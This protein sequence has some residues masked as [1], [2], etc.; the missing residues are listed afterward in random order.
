MKAIQFSKAGAAK[1]VL[2]MV[3]IAPVPPA[4]GEV[5]VKIAYSAVNPTDVKR[6]ESGRELPNFSPII[7]GNDGAGIIT[8][9]GDG[10]EASRVGERVW[11]FGA[12]A[13]RA[14]GTEAEYCTLPTWMAPRLPD[15]A[16]LADGACLGVPAVTA[17]YGVFSD[18]PVEGLWVMV[19]G[20]AGRVGR[21]AVQM[22]KLAG[23]NV[24]ASVGN[25]AKAK[26]A[27]DAGA[28]HVIN[29]KTEDVRARVLEIT[30]GAG[31]NR[32][33]EVAFGANI[34]L[35][36]DIMAPNGVIT[37]YSSDAVPEP[38]L[39]YWPIMFKNITIRPY[40]IYAL[41]E[42]VKKTTFDGVNALL[43]AGQLTHMVSKTCPFTL[44]GVIDAHE[45][46]ESSAIQGVCLIKV[47]DLGE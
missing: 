34:D 40:T 36:A 6:R 15:G 4:A 42:A 21:Y 44:D 26:I 29:Y 18:G 11:I 43:A 2:E 47:A 20:G 33:S 46:I 7:S 10:V 27:I 17:H 1:Q 22:A 19:S 3:D 9:V 39:P 38:V 16:S 30:D 35:F 31:V 45:T 41:T 25:D 24:I 8:A 14:L 13:G 37:T 5:Q 23:A 12:Q 28:D 32:L